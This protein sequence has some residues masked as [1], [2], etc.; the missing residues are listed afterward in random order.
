MDQDELVTHVDGARALLADEAARGGQPTDS[1]CEPPGS[2][3][4]VTDSDLA[5]LRAKFPFLKEFSDG[6]IKANKPDCLMRMETANMKLREAERTKDAEDKLAHNR[7]NI[8]VIS[9]DMGLDDGHD[10]AYLNLKKKTCSKH[11][12]PFLTY[13]FEFSARLRRCSY[14]KVSKSA[15]WSVSSWRELLSDQAVAC[16]KGKNSPARSPTSG[17]L[18]HG[19]RRPWQIRVFSRLGGAGQSS[20]KRV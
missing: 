6:F 1:L 20:L 9:V 15:R 16:G 11:L 8:G 2:G 12:P 18:R 13:I 14:Y 10:N 17:E 19:G 4:A 3:S 7:M 5:A